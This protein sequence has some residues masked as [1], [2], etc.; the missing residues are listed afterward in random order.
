MKTRRLAAMGP[1]WLVLFSV[2][3]IC[4]G[5]EPTVQRFQ[6]ERAV[7]LAQV[8][9]RSEAAPRAD[10][11]EKPCRLTIE[12]LVGED[13]KPVAGLIRVTNLE[14]GKE[15]SFAEEIHRDKN[16]YAVSPSTTL[17]VPRTKLKVELV[18]GLET[19][20]ATREIDLT[21]KR[22][23]TLSIPLQR[24]YNAAARGACRRE[25]PTYT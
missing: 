12:L 19:E 20:L 7:A 8:A 17:L 1:W 15:I 13:P 10:A 14:S 9:Q 3:R 6:R 21:G 5:H 16:W 23:Q 24:F 4:A 22:M 25:T 18:H 11:P 2:A